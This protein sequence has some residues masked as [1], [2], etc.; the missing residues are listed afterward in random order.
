MLK[1]IKSQDEE[2]GD[3]LTFYIDE[4]IKKGDSKNIRV[5][6]N[7]LLGIPFNKSTAD[8]FFKLLISAEKVNILEEAQET[9]THKVLS[10]SYSANVGKAPPALINKK[11]ILIELYEKC[12]PGIIKD[13]LDSLIKSI[14]ADIQWNIDKGEEFKSPK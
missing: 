13:Y 9:F 2:H 6:S 7:I 10:G 1:N 5:A 3:Y 12:R 8:L 4:K 14:S 11:G